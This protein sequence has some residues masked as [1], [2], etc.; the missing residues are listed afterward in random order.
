M[1]FEIFY[2]SLDQGER[3]MFMRFAKKKM[4]EQDAM[5]DGMITV[6]VFIK[7][8]SGSMTQRLLNGMNRYKR[9]L[10]KYIE[11][12]TEDRFK[13]VPVFGG[14]AWNEFV[15]LRDKMTGVTQETLN[16]ARKYYEKDN[17][18]RQG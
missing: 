15:E 8:M 7:A 13:R 9:W 14:K 4:L 11:Q 2:Q 10:P 17:D 12:I 3:E 1:N 6:T 18:L 16:E 5:R